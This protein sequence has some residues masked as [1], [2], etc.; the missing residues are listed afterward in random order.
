MND[1]LKAGLVGELKVTVKNRGSDGVEP[2]D[3]RDRLELQFLVSHLNLP[4]CLFSQLIIYSIW[5]VNPAR[6]YYS[7]E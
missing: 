1:G 6:A 4:W 7:A 3:L 2:R 5:F